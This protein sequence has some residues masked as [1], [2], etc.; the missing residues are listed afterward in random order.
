MT[1][2]PLMGTLMRLGVFNSP[3]IRFSLKHGARR[4]K[5][6]SSTR[7]SI[8][9]PVTVPR[10]MGFP[11]TNTRLKRSLKATITLRCTTGKDEDA[12]K[13]RGTIPEILFRYMKKF[14]YCWFK[15][16]SNANLPL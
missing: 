13:T 7:E 5:T 14:P 9:T 4:Q 1:T 12:T 16:F 6:T 11:Q 15:R 3:D 10:P 8:P 2:T